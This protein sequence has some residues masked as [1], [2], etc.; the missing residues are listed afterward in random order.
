[1]RCL[2]D[3]TN[4]KPFATFDTPEGEERYEKLIKTYAAEAKAKARYVKVTATNLTALP[5]WR[6]RDNKK[7]MIAC[8]EVYV[9]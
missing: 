6:A 7:P 8:S 5:A 3:G 1:M 9:Q 4:Y 2:W